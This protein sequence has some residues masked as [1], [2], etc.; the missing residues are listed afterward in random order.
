MAWVR[1]QERFVYQRVYKQLE[2]HLMGPFGWDGVLLGRMPWGAVRPLTMQDLPLDP[3]TGPL[4]PNAVALT[5]GH[6]PDDVEIELGEGLFE[7]TSTIFIDIFGESMSV[8]KSLASDIRS[9][10]TG[11]ATG[12]NRYLD[13]LDYSDP[14]EPVL[15]GHLIHLEDIEVAYPTG[16]GEVNWAVVK[17]T[18]IHEWNP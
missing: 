11:R 18:P 2:F 1:G 10:L 13:L 12:T 3:K 16:M 17:V 4:T 7:T 15:P 5:E 9:I 14:A 8:T 6:Q